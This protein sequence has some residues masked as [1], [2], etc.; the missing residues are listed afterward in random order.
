MEDPRLDKQILVTGGT[1][2]LGSYLL[3]YLF[4][5]GYTRIRALKRPN[6]PLDLVAPIQGKVEWVDCDLM[7]AA[8]LE[9]AMA[10][11]DQLY[12]CAAM[13][14]FYPSDRW[15]MLRT[16][17]EG[18]ANVVNSALSQGVG[19]MV[20]VSSVAALG[21]VKNKK[22]VTE[23]AKWERSKLN[24]SYSLSKYLSENEVWRGMAEGLPAAIVNPS[25]ILGSG[26]WQG[27]GPQSFFRLAGKGFPFYPVGTNGFVDVR[28]VARFMILLMESSI[29]G[30]RYILNSDNWSY[31]N[32]LTS[33]ARV[34][35]QRPPRIK[36][37]P[38]VQQVAWRLEW[39]RQKLTGARPVVT[40]ETAR[41][42]ANTFHYVNKKSIEAFNFE[43]IPLVE[44]I[45]Q[46]SLQYLEAKENNLVPKL[47]ELV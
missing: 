33:I 46:T 38:L 11:V 44:T 20:H 4:R 47:L 9:D 17:V 5:N 28:D 6:S 31:Q 27:G 7:E 45:R 43:Y 15:N 1:G 14:S 2:F 18:T 25:I 42:A 36:V 8:S 40:R 29:T 12:H 10:G 3:R 23:A 30:E 37:T 16:N 32:L 24:S 39:I 34:Q 22:I 21:R 26:F 41:T 13:I 35:Q 19:R